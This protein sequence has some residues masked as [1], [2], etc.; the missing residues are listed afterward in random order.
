MKVDDQNADPIRLKLL[1]GAP[2]LQGENQ[3]YVTVEC[4]VC[5]G[6]AESPGETKIICRPMDVPESQ[7]YQ[8]TDSDEPIFHLQK[9]RAIPLDILHTEK[10]QILDEGTWRKQEDKIYNKSPASVELLNAEE[11]LKFETDGGL[12]DNVV[13]SAGFPLPKELIAVVRPKSSCG[14]NVGD[15]T[16]TSKSGIICK[17]NQ[18]TIV[19]EFM[20]MMLEV[21]FVEFL[22][23]DMKVSRQ[24]METTKVIYTCKVKACTRCNI[25]GLYCFPT[26]KSIL[27]SLFNRVGT[28]LFSFSLISSK[29]DGVPTTIVR[30]NVAADDK[31]DYWC[32]CSHPGDCQT[33]HGGQ[34]AKTVKARLGGLVEDFLYLS[35]FDK[36]GNRIKFLSVPNDLHLELANTEGKVLEI[37]ASV[38]KE[39]LMLMKDKSALEFTG[40]EISG[41]NS[42]QIAPTYKATL[43]MHLSNALVATFNLN[44][45]PGELVYAT[46]KEH[47][48][49][50]NCLRPHQI[51]QKFVLQA[52][53]E[54]GNAVEEGQK[55]R[56]RLDGFQFQDKQGTERKVF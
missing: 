32:L 38:G 18:K 25:K 45:L 47:D 3:L 16:G 21:R 2:G 44:V 17:V 12:A 29:Y 46:V 31:V 33:S 28:Y 55:I 26:E 9:S 49:L 43:R 14:W 36:Y 39:G 53:D 10:Y 15:S 8:L 37:S 11:A 4:F 30:V 5:E 20:E 54:Y 56:L 7:G 35:K 50:H 48:P 51:V 34:S 1:K 19:A 24:Q 27:D 22:P 52:M 40:I 6:L 42:L 41:G 23:P 13:V